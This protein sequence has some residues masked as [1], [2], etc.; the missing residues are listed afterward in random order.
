MTADIH[1]DWDCPGLGGV[2]RAAAGLGDEAERA[3][4]FRHAAACATCG[5][6]L[7]ALALADNPGTAEEEALV[8]RVLERPPRPFPTAVPSLVTDLPRHDRAR[9]RRDRPRWAA[10][11][12]VAAA[13][14]ACAAVVGL[15]VVAPDETPD[16]ALL[17]AVSGPTRSAEG[18][19][20]LGLPHAPYRPTR[21]DGDELRPID[22]ALARLLAMKGQDP[23]A[24]ARPLAAVYLARAEPGDLARAEA[25]LAAAPA[26]P[27]RDNDRGVVLLAQGRA[28]EALQALRS[29]VAQRPD[30]LPARFNLA[31]ALEATGRRAEAARALRDYLARA[32]VSGAESAWV[33][34]ARERLA[35]IE[36]GDR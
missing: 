18:R 36:G 21:G 5:N 7:L 29:A 26:S 9:T 35:R 3:E 8:A 1:F 32:D 14:L 11:A 15:V 4:A 16:A 20:S 13:A 23:A 24:S 31:L 2:E 33:D 25:E 10:R 19:L 28:E 27:E 17:A 34:E 22:R 12:A 30:F 6:A